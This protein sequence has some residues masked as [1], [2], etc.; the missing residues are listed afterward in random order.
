MFKNV[1][2]RKILGLHFV[3]AHFPC[4]PVEHGTVCSDCDLDQAKN[5]RGN[6]SG[7]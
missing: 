3:V 7:K 4:G 1:G 6:G 5:D 2:N